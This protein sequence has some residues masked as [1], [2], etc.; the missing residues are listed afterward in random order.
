M[1]VFSFQTMSVF[2]L[3]NP[4]FQHLGEILGELEKMKTALS[5]QRKKYDELIQSQKNISPVIPS[6]AVVTSNLPEV[7]SSLISQ[8]AQDSYVILQKILSLCQD[9]QI[10]LHATS[11]LMNIQQ[12]ITAQIPIAIVKKKK[13]SRKKSTSAVPKTIEESLV[14]LVPPETPVKKT[15][16]KSR[17]T[18]KKSTSK[19][20]PVE[21]IPPQ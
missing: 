5:F 20:I 4:F 16:K 17:K 1:S 11:I 6:K 15:T 3:A 19:S 13:S 9:P 2:E 18:T 8:E 7:P 12:L 10:Q 21:E 14:T